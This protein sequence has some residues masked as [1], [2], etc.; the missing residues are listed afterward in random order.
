VRTKEQIAGDI[1]RCAMAHMSDSRLTGNVRADEIALLCVEHVM[2]CPNC[3]AEAWVS[4]DCALC[5]TVTLLQA[6]ARE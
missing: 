1:L 4:I 5:E 3:G 6:E 2:T